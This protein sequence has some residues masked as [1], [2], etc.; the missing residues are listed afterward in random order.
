MRDVEVDHAGLDDGE[1]IFQIDFDNAIQP[2]QRQDDAAFG[3]HRAAGKAGARTARDDR[4]IGVL[5]RFDH[6]GD[7]FDVGRHDDDLRHDLE[8]RTVLLVDDDV[9]FFD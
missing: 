8:D 9:F 5:G 7:F 3:R 1:A 4:H 2:R 6:G